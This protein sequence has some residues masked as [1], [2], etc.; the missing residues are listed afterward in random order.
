LEPS[1]SSRHGTGS[2]AGPRS[3]ALIVQLDRAVLVAL[4]AG[5]ALYV[6]PFWAE[7]RLRAAFWLTLVAA[8]LHIYTSHRRAA[9]NTRSEPPVVIAGAGEESGHAP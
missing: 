5:L 7:G 6:A 9:V 4:A 3:A 2:A 1:S 8:V